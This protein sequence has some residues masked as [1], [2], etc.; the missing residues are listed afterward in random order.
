MHSLQRKAAT[1]V[2]AVEDGFTRQ[3]AGELKWQTE[4][5]AHNARYMHV[6]APAKKGVSSESYTREARFLPRWDQRAVAPCR[7][8]ANCVCP[9]T[10]RS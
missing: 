7:L 3:K 10:H 9:C 6:T 5:A 4:I 1:L 2:F 8:S